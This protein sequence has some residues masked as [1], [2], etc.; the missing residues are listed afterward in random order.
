MA[1]GIGL[2]ENRTRVVFH[3][4]LGDT[5]EEQAANKVLKFLKSQH[6]DDSGVKGFTHSAFRPA[7]FRGWWWSDP[8]DDWCD[9]PIVLV[10][11]DYRIDF[12]DLRLSQKIK[13]LKKTIRYWYR[14]FGKP[15]EEIWVVAHQVM[16]FD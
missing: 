7:V 13:E 10:F 11:V 15:Q 2:H 3:L 1:K 9:D 6:E 8:A 16:R 5:K 12:G 4:P 14:Y